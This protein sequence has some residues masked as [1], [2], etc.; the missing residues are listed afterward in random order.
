M[1]MKTM[2]NSVHPATATIRS[3]LRTTP[4]HSTRNR[5]KRPGSST[6][7]PK[8]K[9]NENLEVIKVEPSKTPIFSAARSMLTSFFS[10]SSFGR[11]KQN[12]ESSESTTEMSTTIKTTTTTKKT[13]SSPSFSQSL[14][15]S[16]ND[17]AGENDMFET[18][19]Q[20]IES[21]ILH[22]PQKQLK[23]NR[24]PKIPNFS[25]VELTIY[26]FI[27][28]LTLVLDLAMVRCRLIL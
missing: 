13:T 9:R 11:F 4:A 18:T 17:F 19:T 6:K 8:R 20:S 14:S 16:F 3:F 10:M 24:F 1:I 27:F 22:I 7:A 26:F 21:V 12:D 2:T 23:L 28:S 25:V 15:R 5:R